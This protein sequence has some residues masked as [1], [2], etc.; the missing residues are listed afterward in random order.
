MSADE[1]DRH[2][3]KHG[4]LTEVILGVFFEVYRELGYGFAESVYRE[5]M[6]I[7]LEE[8]GLSAKAE[9]P[10]D[11]YFRGR[12][13]GRFGADLLVGDRVLLELKATPRL[14]PGHA[15]QLLGYLRCSRIE[16]GLVLNFGSRPQT[17]RLIFSNTRKVPIAAR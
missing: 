17:R 9:Y 4:E 7:A 15:A 1:A 6:A 13:V 5:A 12:C 10:L 2:G 3:L 16:V 8:A 11:A 14:E